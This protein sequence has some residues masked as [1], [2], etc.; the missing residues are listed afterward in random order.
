MYGN[1]DY[2]PPMIN[3]AFVL[4]K[5]GMCQEI[6]CSDFYS[7]LLPRPTIEY[8][9]QTKIKRLSLKSRTTWA[10][11]AAF[12]L[13]VLRS[14]DPR[15]AFFVGYNTHSL[16]G[17]RLLATRYRRPLVYH[18]HDYTEKRQK[19]TLSQRI[20]KLLE[21]FI[22]RTADLVIVPDAERA[23]FMAR[24]LRLWR[25]P[26]VVANAALTSPDKSTS[27]LQKVLAGCGKYFEQIVFRPGFVGDG[28]AL[29]QT[30]R[31]IPLWLNPNWGFVIM[32]PGEE[33]Y[34]QSLCRLAQDVGVQDRFE[35]LPE[36]SY[37]D[38]AHY[39]VGA[40]LG[41]G[42][43]DPVH[44]NNVFITLA[45]NKIME[46]MA[47]GLPLLLSDNPASNRALLEK[48][49]NGVAVQNDSVE[50]IAA[51][52]NSVLGSPQTAK[53]MGQGSKR[54]FQEEFNYAHQYAPAIAKFFELA[55]R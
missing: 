40:H 30:I 13:Q 47:A 48:Y 34:K 10:K 9:S 4:S 7:N 36:V 41:H 42:L 16:L 23:A 54:A 44:I 43:Y 31:S 53:I 17:A 49:G 35:I 46:Y 6:L 51:G 29:Q 19:L 2:Y 8:P 3:A 50:S 18:C 24:E 1:P 11:Y 38:V 28:H 22:A 20:F 33:S 52:V 39:T 15:A 21:Q 14:G 12:T 55:R 37:S 32:G 45:S 25:P 27:V 5:H 26:L